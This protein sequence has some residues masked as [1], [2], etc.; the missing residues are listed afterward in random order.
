VF[1]GLD[2]KAALGKQESLQLS[3]STCKIHLCSSFV[4]NESHSKYR[5]LGG[6]GTSN[7]TRM[8]EVKPWLVRDNATYQ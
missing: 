1:N 3:H 2:A 6:I 8:C 7:K 5:H 4:N